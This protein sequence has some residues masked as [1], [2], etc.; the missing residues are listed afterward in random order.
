MYINC[1]A[2]LRCHYNDFR[3]PKFKDY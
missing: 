3:Q 1:A 2:A